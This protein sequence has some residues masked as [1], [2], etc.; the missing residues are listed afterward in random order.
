MTVKQLQERLSK[1][2]QDVEVMYYDG[3]NGPTFVN[4]VDY[5]T[6]VVIYP[7]MRGPQRA[8]MNVV[9]LGE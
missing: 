5:E 8:N 1:M 3:D 9:V 2:P 7:H 6:S 4:E